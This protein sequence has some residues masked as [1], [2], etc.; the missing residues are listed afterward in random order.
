MGGKAPSMH[1]AKLL[2]GLSART[3]FESD[4]SRRNY[5]RQLNEA[6]KTGGVGARIPII[7]RA[8]EAQSAANQQTNT[9]NREKVARAGLG[10]SAFDVNAQLA[11]HTIQS[12]Q[13][14]G[15]GPSMAQAM[16]GEAPSL[17]TG[18]TGI[19]GLSA[20]A[21]TESQAAGQASASQ[22]QMV[23]GAGS[24]L[25]SLGA[26]YLLSGSTA[27][28]GTTAAATGTA[29]VGAGGAATA[30]GVGATAGGSTGGAAVESIVAAILA[31][32]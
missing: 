12:R 30:G 20:A 14:A 17:I 11:A 1:A 27:A 26:A 24:A 15:I 3:F 28:A 19:P 7:Q 29:A 4:P 2:A 32:L 31:A 16:I 8:I 10:G 21:A 23:G 18:A 22:A 6:L 25:G 13:L 9:L 5:F